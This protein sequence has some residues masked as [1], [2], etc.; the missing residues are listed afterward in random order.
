MKCGD[1]EEGSAGT[2]RFEHQ[3]PGCGQHRGFAAS[4]RE[5]EGP[6]CDNDGATKG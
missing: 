5:G 3:F 4:S 6:L 2:G 1:E